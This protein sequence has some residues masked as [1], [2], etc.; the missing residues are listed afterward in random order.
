MRQFGLDSFDVTALQSARH[1][2]IQSL[3]VINKRPRGKITLWLP[4]QQKHELVVASN[5]VFLSQRL[6]EER[7]ECHCLF[8]NCAY[9][10]TWL[11]VIQHAKLNSELEVE[12]YPDSHTTKAMLQAGIHGDSITLSIFAS[13]HEKITF[14]LD[15]VNSDAK[16]LRPVK[17]TL[18]PLQEELVYGNLERQ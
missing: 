4:N 1:L 16:E 10:S 3:F 2:A 7:V 8:L 11:T 17:L 15:V 14:L 9:N 6:K 5:I 18:Q 13:D 12:W